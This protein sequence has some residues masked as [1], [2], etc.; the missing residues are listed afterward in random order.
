MRGL[1]LRR[2]VNK[3]V[4]SGGM[5][6]DSNRTRGIAWL[7]AGLLMACGGCGGGGTD[8]PTGDGTEPPTEETTG[9]EEV[10]TPAEGP[11]EDEAAVTPGAL[12]EALQKALESV[13][14]ASRELTV[15]GG[16][17]ASDG[18]APY[19]ASCASCH[20][21]SGKG[22]GASASFLNPGPGDWTTGDRFGKTRVGEKFYLVTHGVG[23]GSAMPGY[24]AAMS[25]KQIWAII[26]HVQTLGP[27][28]PDAPAPEPPAAPEG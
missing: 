9:A 8:E 24:E 13:P 26:A 18:A 19:E 20:G 12:S 5:M 17:H 22:D 28:A 3:D 11:T 27:S 4:T 2:K 25:D 1:Y 14:E 6:T 21:I 23:G 10:A 7:L 15:P 16:I